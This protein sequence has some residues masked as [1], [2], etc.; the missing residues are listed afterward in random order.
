[1]TAGSG[2]LI[3]MLLFGLA[4]LVGCWHRCQS[5]EPSSTAVMATAQRLLHP[6]VT[7]STPDDCSSCRQQAARSTPHPHLSSPIRPWREVKSRRG[8]HRNALRPRVLLPA[9]HLRLLPYDGRRG[10]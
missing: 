6:E 4:W 9:T 10:A 2:W 7:R 3:L 5:A 1:M 8:A